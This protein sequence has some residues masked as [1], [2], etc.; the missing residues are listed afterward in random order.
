MLEWRSDE[1]FPPEG[2]PEDQPRRWTR[3]RSRL[4][5]GLLLAAALVG[6]LGLRS[7]LNERREAM[8]RDV[9]A[10]AEQEERLRRFGLRE[11]AEELV[12]PDAPDAWRAAYLDS[13]ETSGD[14]EPV[15]LEVTA[16]SFD[17]NGALATLRLGEETNQRYYRLAGTSWR[18]APIP[19]LA[20]GAERRIELPDGRDVVFHE[21]DRAFAE[22]LAHDLPGLLSLLG[23]W[24]GAR[25]VHVFRIEPG[26]FGEAVVRDRSFQIA[27][28][29]PAL[30]RRHPD[31]LSPDS[32]VRLALA[33]ALF[34]RLAPV[35]DAASSLPGAPSFFAAASTVSATRWALS[36]PEQ[37]RM[38]QRWRGQLEHGW[39]SPFTS[40]VFDGPERVTF[41]YTAAARVAMLLTADHIER[42]HGSETLTT[43]TRKLRRAATWDEVFQATLRQ[44]PIMVEG[45]VAAEAG[46][47]GGPT[48]EALARFQGSTLQV[49]WL[50]QR[51][52]NASVIFVRVNGTGHPI[53]VDLTGQ[54]EF[55]GIQNVPLNCL[56]AQSEVDIQGDWLEVGYRMRAN[57][58]SVRYVELPLAIDQAPPDTIAYLEEAEGERGQPAR[59]LALRNDGSTVQ[60]GGLGRPASRILASFTRG[61]GAAT[62]LVDVGLAD[63]N[64]TWLI[65]ADPLA[66]TT[67]QWL[68]PQSDRVELIRRPDRGDLLL[69]QTSFAP[70][71]GSTAGESS[72]QYT[73]LIP[74]GGLLIS[75]QTRLSAELWP[76]GWS[77]TTQRLVVVYQDTR[78]GLV[79]LGSAQETT[80][81]DLQ[82]AL[83]WVAPPQAAGASW[84]AYV[85]RTTTGSEDSYALRL[86]DLAT[87]ADTLVVQ[88]TDGEALG[89]PAWS[90]NPAD[91]HLI[92]AAGAGDRRDLV[93]MRLLAVRPNPPISV[94][95]AVEFAEDERLISPPVVCVDGRLL[96]AVQKN[97]RIFTR[98]HA[99]GAEP[100]VVGE[101]NN[102]PLFPLACPGV[103]PTG[104]ASRTA[105][106][107]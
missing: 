24:P 44:L 82:G 3:R 76:W 106:T 107:H 96:Y 69:F 10:F 89:W 13:F 11:R 27:I 62:L 19:L 105:E 52:P 34:Q 32:T 55:T 73:R 80:W 70:Q 6:L 100:L 7:R 92:V 53:L 91:E 97:D 41:A 51:A 103:S 57:R 93:P 16:V 94:T 86:L 71:P 26:E 50:P 38:V 1:A 2:L 81:Y 49:N 74:E 43:M 30:I 12:A 58:I 67:N 60:I 35:Q 31:D 63:C 18:R 84:F 77:P 54:T 14:A 75:Q 28:N 68:T 78:V 15:E 4:V 17:G 85:T 56:P 59:L 98:L 99:P 102:R 23:Q 29:S 101:R 88:G 21:R 42:A 66:G 9:V 90:P 25:L 37:E 5:L 87:G 83:F 36:P 8:R 22:R 95:V 104:P 64:A 40:A 20:W 61:T 46:I 47:P 48:A 45:Q 33:Q 65:N 39:V 72:W 79:D